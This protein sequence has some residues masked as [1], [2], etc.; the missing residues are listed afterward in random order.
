[1]AAGAPSLPDRLTWRDTEFEVAHMLKTWKE[2]SPDKDHTP[3][4]YLR[5]H[6]FGVKT[7]DGSIMMIYFERKS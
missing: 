4:T 3:N 7:A 5:K 6:L 2:S 1:M